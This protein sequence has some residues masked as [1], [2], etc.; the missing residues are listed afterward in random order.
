MFSA[1]GKLIRCGSLVVAASVLVSVTSIAQTSETG[2]KPTATECRPEGTSQYSSNDYTL[3][4]DMVAYD[5]GRGFMGGSV[6][7]AKVLQLVEDVR[8]DS[9][10]A[11][12]R[13]CA[14]RLVERSLGN[15]FPVKKNMWT[16][17]LTRSE[18]I[19]YDDN[20][21][22]SRDFVVRMTGVP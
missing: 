8:F 2:T 1:P 7:E 3:F 12:I 11:L 21:Q 16:V 18:V 13:A 6:M 5:R 20:R 10:K 22:F 19:L 17:T 9:L 14:S 4:N 15:V